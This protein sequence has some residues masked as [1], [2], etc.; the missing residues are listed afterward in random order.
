MF[1][2]SEFM[3]LSPVFWAGASASTLQLC[4]TA[5][6]HCR[7]KTQ[8]LHL[9]LCTFHRM[10]QCTCT[11]SGHQLQALTALVA[12]ICLRVLGDSS[13]PMSI[14]RGRS[15]VPHP[16]PNQSPSCF[17]PL[18]GAGRVEL[19]AVHRNEEG[20]RVALRAAARGVPADSV[21][22]GSRRGCAAGR[23]PHVPGANRAGTVPSS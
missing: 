9:S 12:F 1:E 5:Q 22:A 17:P 23:Q 21:P 14:T 19:A 13:L 3:V 20:Q 11:R 15:T 6:H 2:A 4:H 18:K 10:Q 7:H 8:M 16:E